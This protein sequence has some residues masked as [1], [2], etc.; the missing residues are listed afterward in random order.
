MTLR[1]TVGS[2]MVNETL[3]KE[4]QDHGRQLDAKGIGKLLQEVAEKHPDQYATVL[5]RLHNVGHRAALASG[6]LSF[7]IEHLKKVP[8]ARLLAEQLRAKAKAIYRDTSLSPDQKDEKLT[9]MLAGAHK[10]LEASVMKDAEES[11]NPFFRQVASGAKGKAMNLK[12][13]LGMDLQYVDHRDRPIAIPILRSYSQGLTPVEYFAGSFGTRKGLIDL[14]MA[15]PDAGFLSKQLVQASHRLVVEGRDHPSWDGTLR[16][17][18]VDTTDPDNSGAM[19]AHDVGGYKRGT[20]LNGRIMADIDGQGVNKILVR[21]PTTFGTPH[22]GVYASDVGVRERG[23]LPPRGDFV[24]IAAAQA[25]AEP[26]A[27]AAISSKHSGG[28]AG[29]S[30]AVGGFKLINQFVQVPKKFQGGAAHS[31][32]DGRVQS[33]EPA[34]QG[35]TYVNVSGEKHYVGQGFDL[36]V[37]P[38]DTV[39]AGDVLSAGWPNP[40]EIVQHKGIGEGRAYLVRSLMDAYKDAGIGAH[41]RN[42]ELVSRALIDHVRMTEPHDDYLPDD[43][44][45]YSRLEHDYQPREGHEVADV[46]RAKDMYLEKPVLHYSIGTIVRPSVVK[47]LQQFGVKNVVVHKDPPPFQAEMIRGMENLAHD[48][49]WMTRFLGSYLQKN[50][51]RGVARGARSE[52][53]GTSYVPALARGQQFGQ[54]GLTQGWKDQDGPGAT[55]PPTAPVGPRDMTTPATATS[56]RPIEAHKPVEAQKPSFSLAGV[57]AAMAQAAAVKPPA[58]V[59]PPVTPPAPVKPPVAAPAPPPPA[60]TAPTPAPTPATATTA[61]PASQPPPQAADTQL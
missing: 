28:V 34:P 27:Q 1:T 17:L 11:G 36:K 15:T 53:T 58:P 10:G 52:E 55:M 42:V 54:I 29:A 9:E 7:G 51:L 37:K 47:N 25:L 23:R 20:I 16:G 48:P 56:W 22:G 26:L 38:G 21:S 30:K 40:K 61:L 4:M 57:K 46:T 32:L 19:L 3:P 44:V 8:S 60:Q 35:G 6:G 31:Q 49:D 45:P 33:I 50:L 43:I 18:P 41:R 12:S 5:K 2:L 59:S 39:E 13:L 14:K 24:G